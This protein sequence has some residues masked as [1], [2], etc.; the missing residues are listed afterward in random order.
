MAIGSQQS[1]VSKEAACGG[2]ELWENPN[3]CVHN[4]GLLTISALLWY[5]LDRGNQILSCSLRC[6][7]EPEK[8]VPI[9]VCLTVWRAWRHP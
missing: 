3:G 1:V 6:I 9:A 2:S 5:L 8:G 4:G 7:P